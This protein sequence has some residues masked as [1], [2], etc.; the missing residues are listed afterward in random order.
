MGGIQLASSIKASRDAKKAKQAEAASQ[1]Q[2]G[3][4]GGQ[5]QQQ[6]AQLFQQGMP[7]LQN[8]TGYYS[9]L[10]QG[11]RGAMNQAVAGPTAQ[12]TS[13]YRGAERGLDRGMIRGGVR[14]VA[15]AELGRDKANS[16]AQLTTGVQPMAAGALGALGGGA[17]SA[18]MG[19]TAN[20]GQLF[21]SLAHS[22]QNSRQLSAGIDR[23]NG[24]DMGASIGTLLGGI[25][26]GRNSK[27][28]K[29]G[30]D[31]GVF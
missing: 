7:A 5:L 11:N 23:Q 31:P 29:S 8:A 24:Q 21:G 6:G 28:P 14:D 25:Q 9:T 18:G 13:L 10:L 12:I 20:A 30:G 3:Q 22:Q 1:Q 4:I 27:A 16:L 15:R 19:G 2:Q 26:Q 17:V